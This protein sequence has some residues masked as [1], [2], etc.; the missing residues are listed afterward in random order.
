[1]RAHTES[2]AD[3]E[4]QTAARAS[5]P[6]HRL[7]NG[8]LGALR[9]L[10]L[11][12]GLPE[13][14]L[15]EIAALCSVSTAHPGQVAQ[16]QDVPIRMWHVISGGYAVVQRDGTPIGLLGRGDSWSEHSIL[17]GLRSSIAVVALSPLTLLTLSQRSFFGIPDHHPVLA[18]RLVAR[19]AF[20]PDR[21]AVPVFNALANRADTECTG[22]CPGDQYD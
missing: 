21:L 11:F 1:V 15:E 9:S 12:T 3:T 20:S 8:D 16:A 7:T 19:A 13:P 17:N 4:T 10:S 18:G 22:G 14:E 6:V 2:Q 5:A